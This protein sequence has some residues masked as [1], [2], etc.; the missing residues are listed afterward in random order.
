MGTAV[1]P[2]TCSVIYEAPTYLSFPAIARAGERLV[3]VFRTGKG[4]PLDFDS[5][6]LITASDDDGRTWSGPEVWVD[7]PD[8]DSRNCGG[9]TLA[10]G[11]AH[12]VYDLHLRDGWRRPYVTFTTDGASWSSPVWLN[13]NVPGKGEDQRTSVTN[14]GIEWDDG[15]LYFPCFRGNSVLFDSRTGAQEQRPTVPR[16]EPAIAWNGPGELVAFSKGGG[17]DISSDH[18]KTWVA[19]GDLNSISQPDLVQLRDGRLLFCFSGKMRLDEWLVVSEDGHDVYDL[20]PVR[21]FDGT[22]DGELDSRGKAMCI[23][24]GEEILTV[25]YE[26][27]GPRGNSRIYLVRTPKGA[28]G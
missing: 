9:N 5:R 20:E 18:G 13:A 27:C 21:I 15:R 1:P 11:T 24:H 23:E 17:V 22:P 8:C 26:A 28:L 16:H 4:N 6:I 2:S 12:F 25:L 3:V 7:V 19:A 14:Q 10:D